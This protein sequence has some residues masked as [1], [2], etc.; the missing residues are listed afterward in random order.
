MEQNSVCENNLHKQ[1][2]TTDWNWVFSHRMLWFF[3]FFCPHRKRTNRDGCAEQKSHLPQHQQQWPTASLSESL[4]VKRCLTNKTQ[5]IKNDR[6][7]CT[8]SK[9]R[10]PFGPACCCSV[11][12]DKPLASMKEPRSVRKYTG[13][14][15]V[16]APQLLSIP[17]LTTTLLQR[18]RGLGLAQ[19]L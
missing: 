12:S 4:S 16:S 3:F 17:T 10:W 13:R 5:L 14:G 2:Q 9:Y 19:I 1:I 8:V 18:R 11:F 7:D 15:A 6:N